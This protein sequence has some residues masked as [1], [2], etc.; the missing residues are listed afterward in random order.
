MLQ[1]RAFKAKMTYIK[2]T[3]DVGAYVNAY[4]VLYNYPEKFSKLILYLGDF[5]LMKEVFGSIGN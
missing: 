2:M 4:R 1:T 5:L 3:L